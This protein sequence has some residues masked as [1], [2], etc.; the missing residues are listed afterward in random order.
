MTDIEIIDKVLKSNK[1]S[2]IFIGDWKPVYKSYRL[3]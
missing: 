3:L 1:P 2:D